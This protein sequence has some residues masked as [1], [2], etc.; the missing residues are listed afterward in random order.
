M[1]DDSS[2]GDDDGEDVE[3]IKHMT[4]DV[5]EGTAHYAK[6]WDTEKRTMVKPG[7]FGG[8]VNKKN[9][10]K[11]TIA[12][13]RKHTLKRDQTMVARQ[14]QALPTF[15]PWFTYIICLLQVSDAYPLVVLIIVLA[16]AADLC[17]HDGLC[18]HEARDGDFWAA[19]QGCHVHHL[20]RL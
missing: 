12:P 6:I 11:S 17:W 18:V 3:R 15:T 14:L 7:W 10:R 2:S 5:D 13:K 8:E 20:A 19:E 4:R 1:E 16:T 9:A